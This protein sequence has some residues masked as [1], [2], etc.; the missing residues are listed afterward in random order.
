[1]RCLQSSWKCCSSARVA[2]RLNVL[3]LCLSTHPE[4]DLGSGDTICCGVM[5]LRAPDGNS[6]TIASSMRGIAISL[7][8]SKGQISGTGQKSLLLIAL[9]VHQCILRLVAH[10]QQHFWGLQSCTDHSVTRRAISALV[11]Q[12][13]SINLPC[14]ICAIWQYQAHRARRYFLPHHCCCPMGV[15]FLLVSPLTS[16]S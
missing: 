11:V 9:I 10:T 8:C 14:A 7:P 12:S 1:M 3:I 15:C 2:L 16:D 4:M 13:G 5:W 6:W